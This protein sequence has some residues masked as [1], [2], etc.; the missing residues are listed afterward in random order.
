M[1]SKS[2][3]FGRPRA[4]ALQSAPTIECHV[5]S[6][7][8]STPCWPRKARGDSGATCS[9][10]HRISRQRQDDAA[11]AT[12]A[13]ARAG[14]YRGRDQ[15]AGRSRPR[16][17]AGRSRQRRRRRAARLRLPVLR[18]RQFAA[19]DAREPAL[20]ARAQASCP[21]FARVVVETTGVA[22]PG[23]IAATLSLDTAIARHY[24]PGSIVTVVDA[25]NGIDAPRTLRRSAAAGCGRR[26]ASWCRSA[27]S[28]MQLPMR[29]RRAASRAQSACASR[30]RGDVGADRFRRLRTPS[31]ARSRRRRTITRTTITS[32]SKA[33]PRRTIRLDAPLPWARYAAW[34]QWMQRRSA[35]ACCG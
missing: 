29:S 4:A 18:A 22:D 25:T 31:R 16:S 1:R 8:I 33:S 12:A 21:P 5:R 28:L 35:S 10:P 30:A 14:G 20:P 23:P 32:P 15:R 26:C 19:G 11:V 34:V 17:R 27:T 9:H 3:G 13:S 2:G 6:E 24:R 7:R